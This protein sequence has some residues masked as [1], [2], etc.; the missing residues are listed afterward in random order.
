MKNKHYFLLSIILFFLQINNSFSQCKFIFGCEYKQ[1][2]VE[3]YETSDNEVYKTIEHLVKAALPTPELSLIEY[4]KSVSVSEVFKRFKNAQEKQK[5]SVDITTFNKPLI[6]L[7]YRTRNNSIVQVIIKIIRS[8]D[9][10]KYEV[11][12]TKIGEFDSNLILGDTDLAIKEIRLLLYKSIYTES[13]SDFNTLKE[14]NIFIGN[15]NKGTAG[16][17]PLTFEYTPEQQLAHEL[18]TYFRSKI[19]RDV[20][21]IH[22]DNSPIPINSVEDLKERIKGKN[23]DIALWAEDFYE[24]EGGKKSIKMKSFCPQCST[25]NSYHFFKIDSSGYSSSSYNYVLENFVKKKVYKY[26]LWKL[27]HIKEYK[28]SEILHYYNLI[29]EQV[30]AKTE[31]SKKINY[32]LGNANFSLNYNIDRIKKSNNYFNRS[33]DD[34]KSISSSCK[35]DCYQNRKNWIQKLQLYREINKDD[36]ILKLIEEQASSFFSNITISEINSNEE[37]VFCIDLA[38]NVNYKSQKVKSL[39]EK[40]QNS[41]VPVVLDALIHYYNK[42]GQGAEQQTVAKEYDQYHEGTR[43]AENNFSNPNTEVNT[44]EA[45]AIEI[46]SQ[47]V[48]DPKVHLCLAEKY[49]KEDNQQNCLFHY[50]MAFIHGNDK[51]LPK[52]ERFLRIDK[53]NQETTYNFPTSP[54]HT[55]NPKPQKQV[56]QHIIYYEHKP[57]MFSKLVEKVERANPILAE[58]IK[59]RYDYLDNKIIT[60]NDKFI[61]HD[62]KRAILHK[63]EDGE[64]IGQLFNLYDTIIFN[65]TV[66]EGNDYFKDLNGLDNAYKV[67]AGQVIIIALGDSTEFYNTN[68]RFIH[69]ESAFD[70]WS[71]KN[72]RLTELNGKCQKGSFY[73]KKKWLKIQ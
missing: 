69:C 40:A 59:N 56:S 39:L 31:E 23:I 55:V 70:K 38:S 71:E 35:I 3:S 30:Q 14:V 1:V 12:R 32:L 17:K 36:E 13:P 41:K 47:K 60:K 26:V 19:D 11:K 52:I 20:V 29:E 46:F 4:D 6:F 16:T 48:N 2:Y 44:K 21:G 42:E 18:S 68:G 28:S 9:D 66:K 57:I 37:F 50:T 33:F 58:E 10:K 7:E 61:I 53:K 25:E 64:S 27:A 34:E 49:K 22:I 63:L 62:G 72:D 24:Y 73:T 15:L 8:I 43:L 54:V 5:I 51:R 45:S 67:Q 65:K